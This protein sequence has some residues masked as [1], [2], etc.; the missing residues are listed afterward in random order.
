VIEP[1]T[2]P[3]TTP[4]EYAVVVL[5][6]DDPV[7][8]RSL[9]DL[10]TDEGFLVREVS[11]VAGVESA[12]A[13]GMPSALVLDV[14]LADGDVVPVLSRL[15]RSPERPHTVLISASSG[16]V[17]LAKRHGLELLRKP[18]ELHALVEALLPKADDS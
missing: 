10:L 6:E 2:A 12:L 14:N 17:S 11:D 7:L 9:S 15:A 5:A 8:R 3:T 4:L 18:F 13:A 16:A 1:G